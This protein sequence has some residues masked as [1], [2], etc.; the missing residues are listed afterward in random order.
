MSMNLDVP[1]NIAKVAFD[2]PLNIAKVDRKS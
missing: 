1:L 2:V